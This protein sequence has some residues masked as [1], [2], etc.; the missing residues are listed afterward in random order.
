MYCGVSSRLLGLNQNTFY[1]LG[2]GSC[3][4]LMIGIVINPKYIDAGTKSMCFTVI[5]RFVRSGFCL[6]RVFSRV[7]LIFD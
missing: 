5:P 4:F 1:G 7:F 3:W 6:L 2:K